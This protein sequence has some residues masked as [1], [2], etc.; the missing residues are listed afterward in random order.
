LKSIAAAFATIVILLAG[1]DGGSDSAAPNPVER[2]GLIE[3]TEGRALVEDAAVAAN[4]ILKLQ[5]DS[6]SLT[7]S[8]E[9]KATD[10]KSTITVYLLDGSRV[11]S[12]YSVMVPNNCR[13][14]FFQP[15]AFAAWLAAHSTA[16][17]QMLSI[18]PKDV[19]TFMF[20]HEIGHI[21]HGDPG[22]FEAQNQQSSYNT[23]KTT[24][25]A[26]EEAA[27]EYAVNLVAV[28]SRGKN[29][30]D[31]WMAAMNVQLVLTNLSWNM[32]EQRFLLHFGATALCSR[33]VFVDAG[34]SHPNFELRMLMANDMLAQTALSRQL[35]EN[36]QACRSTPPSPVLFEN[37]STAQ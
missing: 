24:Q 26:R 18:E 22:Q 35:L 21:V 30:L 15:E 8:W 11:P 4:A 6:I 34:Y 37:R 17:P 7:V 29:S 31:A 28:A 25:K 27:D 32:A 19:L 1:C 36:F 33:S 5:V 16:D 12:S 23:D 14:I 9:P 10:V 13:C 20:L 3:T 2:L